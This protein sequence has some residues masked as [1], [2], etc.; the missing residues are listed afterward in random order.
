M[1]HVVL[2]FS[3]LEDLHTLHSQTDMLDAL[4][5]YF[6]HIGNKKHGISTQNAI[7]STMSESQQH[8]FTNKLYI[9]AG[10][11]LFIAQKSMLRLKKRCRRSSSS[12][13]SLW[14]SNNF[15]LVVLYWHRFLIAWLCFDSQDR[16]NC[17]FLANL[18][19]GSSKNPITGRLI[20]FI[21]DGNI[22]VPNPSDTKFSS[23]AA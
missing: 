13:R 6:W 9:P 21:I 18:S 14:F 11:L 3:S 16:G 22:S 12:L 23:I 4:V 19:L 15:N 10:F 7:E 1:I 20:I 5:W 2:W 17:W 8:N